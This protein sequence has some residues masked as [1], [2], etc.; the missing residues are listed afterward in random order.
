MHFM[1]QFRT[2][3]QSSQDRAFVA[4]GKKEVLTQRDETT[5]N[6]GVRY[7]QCARKRPFWVW[8]LKSKLKA[9]HKIEVDPL[10]WRSGIGGLPLQLFESN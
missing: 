9:H 2:D 3:K 6:V 7:G 10:L 1:P 8:F 5:N 4:G